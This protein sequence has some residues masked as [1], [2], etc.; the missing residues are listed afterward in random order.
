M[1]RQLL[2]FSDTIRGISHPVVNNSMNLIDRWIFYNRDLHLMLYGFIIAI[3][4][5]G[6]LYGKRMLNELQIDDKVLDVQNKSA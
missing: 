5:L 1:P 2:E 6:I 3:Y 4:L